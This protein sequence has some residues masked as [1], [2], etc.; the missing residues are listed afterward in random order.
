MRRVIDPH[1]TLGDPGEAEPPTIVPVRELTL[2][3]ALSEDGKEPE[4]ELGDVATQ[5]HLAA[6]P[7]RPEPGYDEEEE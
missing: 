7:N 4:E 3:D 6:D 1:L 2:P 5:W